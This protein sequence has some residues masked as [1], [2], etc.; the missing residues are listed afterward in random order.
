MD[1]VKVAACVSIN[2]ALVKI[3]TRLVSLQTSPE[4]LAPHS[5]LVCQVSKN[6]VVITENIVTFLT[7]TPPTQSNP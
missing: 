3:A 1:A 6:S 4:Q 2:E 5:L 7:S